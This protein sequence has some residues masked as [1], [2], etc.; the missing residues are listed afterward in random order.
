MS[1]ALAPVPKAEAS[2]LPAFTGAEMVKAFKAYR[3]LQAALDHEMPDQIIKLDGKAF[4]KKGYWRALGVAF[5][6]SVELVEERREV[7][8]TLPSG[9]EN[10]AWVICYRA[11]TATGRSETGDGTCTAAEK[12]VGRMR[13]TEHN[14][15]SHAHTR[16]FNRAVSNLVGFGEVSAEEVEPDE[17]VQEL[18]PA[19]R[20]RPPAQT[21][22]PAVV[23][24]PAVGAVLSREPGD[25]SRDLVYITDVQRSATKNPNV[26]RFT[27]TIAG[28]PGWPANQTTVRTIRKQWGE[29]AE[30]CQKAGAAVRLKVK[31]TDYGL[32]IAAIERVDDQGHP[33]LTADQIPFRPV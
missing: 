24:D 21:A 8:G 9:G 25:K 4:R 15:R 32:D 11:T 23:D 16:A 22:A 3:E 1:T 20:G 33:V 28:G 30:E 7:Y 10:F 19:G 27:L 13:A 2:P 6:L 14:V 12:S 5:N 17:A 29:L 18:E 31:R 26:I